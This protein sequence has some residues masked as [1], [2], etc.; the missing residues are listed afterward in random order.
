[1]RRAASFVLLL[2][3]ACG[4]DDPGDRASDPTP[5]VTTPPVTTPSVTRPSPTPSAVASVEVPAGCPEEPTDLALF[6][7]GGHWADDRGRPFEP[8]EACLVAAGGQPIEVTVHNDPDAEA[9]LS[10]NHNFSLYADADRSQSV[11]NGEL[12]FPGDSL[13]YEVP[14]LEAGAYLFA[15]DIHPQEMTGVLVVT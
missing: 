9:I 8:G 6:A 2:L 4:G 14:A 10:A 12:V 3:V 13:T 11:F 5:S 7:V 1:V 15:C